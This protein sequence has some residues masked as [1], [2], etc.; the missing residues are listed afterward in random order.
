MLPPPQALQAR[1]LSQ[2]H[3]YVPNRTL[4]TKNVFAVNPTSLALQASLARL[5]SVETG[6]VA[7]HIKTLMAG[8]SASL[9]LI[10]RVSKARPPG[11]ET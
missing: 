6:H 7:V 11:W 3:S 4:T 8:P 9:E 1:Y 2:K 5:W 10:E